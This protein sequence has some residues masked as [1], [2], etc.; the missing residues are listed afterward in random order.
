MSIDE[1]LEKNS[2][3]A[4]SGLGGALPALP[5]RNLAVVACM[6]ARVDVYRILGL[7]HGEAH[8]IRNA[9]GIVTDDVIRSLVVSQRKLKTDE[10]VLIHH[11]ACGMRG[12]DEDGLR[13]QLREETGQ[14]TDMSF[15]AFDDVEQ[16]VAD[17]MAALRKN[18]FIE[19]RVIR[20]FVYDLETGLL[21]EVVG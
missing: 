19:A 18:P 12:L 20:G 4:S 1:L 9:G 7:Q 16:S 6:D 3:A 2:Q 10:I 17:S 5:T 8:V 11:T 21:N 14:A 15:G 13:D